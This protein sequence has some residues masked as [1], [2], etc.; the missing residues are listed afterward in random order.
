MAAF[1]RS[2]CTLLAVATLAFALGV[3]STG[4]A[5]DVPAPTPQAECG[6]DDRPEP[7]VQGRAPA[8]DPERLEGYRCNLELVGRH[9]DQGGY[10]VHRYIDESG[11]ECAYYDSTLLFPGSVR[12][13]DLAGVYVL[14]MADPANPVRTTNLVTPAMLSP[15]E[16]LELNQERGLLAA[17]MGYPTFNPGFV[18]IYDVS[19]D[20]RNPVLKSSTPLGVLGHESG[21][22]PDGNT[23]YV[24]STGGGTL[25][26]L[27]VTDPA[28]PQIL[29]ISRD[30]SPHGV[31]ISADGDRLYNSDT[32]AGLI[33]LDVSEIQARES[34]PT[35]EEVS[36]LS[37]DV[38]SIPQVALPVTI[39][40]Q[41]YLVQ[42]DEFSR[43]T[44]T[45]GD[46]PVGAA[47]IIDI[48]DERTPE[49]VS[50]I[51]LEIN[52]PDERTDAVGDPGTSS[53]IQGYTGHYCAVPR[54]VDPGIVACSFVASGLRVFDI[55][56]PLEPREIAY[57][58]HLVD[59]SALEFGGDPS[60]YAMSAPTFAPER[61]EIWY[62]DGNSGF[63]ALRFANDVW[64]FTDG[65]AQRSG[66]DAADEEAISG[67]GPAADSD[68]TTPGTS[69]PSTPTSA[70]RPLP[71]TGASGVSLLGGLVLLGAFAGLRRRTHR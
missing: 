23:F 2:G 62:S 54:E 45:A 31:R 17:G 41:P 8:D 14:D 25:T 32:S 66:A 34:N 24:S 65:E 69:S 20:C 22:A 3:P 6:P 57:W 63:W 50:D 26:A 1:L 46:A 59:A 55:R 28:L 19:E 7:G 60:S 51:R 5:A 15:H 29:W 10:K 70:T 68:V 67:D 44:S 16:S 18:D 13:D 33:V 42:I 52:N 40:G 39:D 56:D 4:V 36:R 47:R 38:M 61:G 37:W 58:N 48:S 11:N 27:D 30:S 35:V 53:G 9:G 21:F 49:V 64:P 71:V 12:N 43:A